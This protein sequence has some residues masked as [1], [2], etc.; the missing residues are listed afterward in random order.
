MN[1]ER[2]IGSVISFISSMFWCVWKNLA[3]SYNT[4]ICTIF[5][6]TVVLV[7]TVV[8][9]CDLYVIFSCAVYMLSLIHI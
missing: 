8:N 4:P 2:W 7:L 6:Q 5:L 1:T 3:V 9:V